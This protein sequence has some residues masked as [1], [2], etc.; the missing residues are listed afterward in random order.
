MSDVL[1]PKEPSI[2][3]PLGGGDWQRVPY[4][5]NP[6]ES[7]GRLFD[8]KTCSMR[9][10]FQRDRD[11]IVHSTAFRRLAHKTQVFVFHEGDHY[12]SRLTHSLEVAQIAR[13]IAR[14]LHLD[15][16]LTEAI[17]LAHDFG[18][19]PFGHAGE[20]ALNRVMRPFGGFDHN[21]QSMH[22][23]TQLEQRYAAFNGLNLTWE[24]L[25]GLVK[26]NGPLLSADPK[27][28]AELL[29]TLPIEIIEYNQKNDLILSGYASAEAQ[30]AAI[31]DD[32]AYNNHDLDDGLR[33]GL[34]DISELE[35]IPL[36][37]RLLADIR[38]LYP[39]LET[40]RVIYE[41][42]RRLITI[43]VEDVVE[44]T[45]QG[46]LKWAPKSVDDVRNAK[47]QL[48]RFSSGFADELKVLQ[49]FLMNEVYH[50]TE[51]KRIMGD[52]EQVVEDLAHYYLKHP[53]KLPS[54]WSYTS[55]DHDEHTRARTVK[56]FVAGMTDLYALEKHRQIFDHTPELR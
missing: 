2:L 48:V 46:V 16:D 5:S 38:A 17:A 43:M 7:R 39:N 32:I 29:P 1:K 40:M 21:A 15:E 8:E 55:D 49:S 25:E 42:N 9:S 4:A 28:Y 50:H 31:A 22:I 34:Y 44:E 54:Q 35:D 14:I 36:I 26:H 6:M 3:P 53:S 20:R 51:I 11:R 12:R 23:V 37:A 47:Q 52:A 45:K 30:V 41:L 27:L 18:H 33:G 10:P 13:S 24:C 19:T 56:D